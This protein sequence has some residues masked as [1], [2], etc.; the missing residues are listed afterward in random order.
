MPQ[1]KQIFA[2]FNQGAVPQIA[3][4]NKATVNLGVTFKK[5]VSA[6]QKF[7]DQ[8]FVPVWG[9]PA[10]L[11]AAKSVPAGAWAILFLDNADQA[12]ALGYHDLTKDGLPLSKVFVK[13]TLADGQKVSVTACHEL[14]EM[15]IDPAINLWAEAPNGA[16]YAYEMSDAVE[17]EEFL[18]DGIAMSDFVYP[19]YFEGFRKPNSVQFDYL[20]K[21][22]RPFQILKGGY[23]IVSKSGKT[24]QIFG[25]AAKGKRF[26]KEDRRQHRSQFRSKGKPLKVRSTAR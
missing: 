17:E 13:T 8:C 7:M 22:R 9:A 23:A 26:G 24:T 11:V 20:K 1:T 3:C 10:K 12:D 16:F 6:M 15:M 18:V 14:A 25:S 2:A 21:V 5:L 19:A 4:V